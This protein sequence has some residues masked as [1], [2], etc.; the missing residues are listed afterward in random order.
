MKK[1]TKTI[2]NSLSMLLVLLSFIL[3]NGSVQAEDTW[4]TLMNEAT[5]YRSKGDPLGAKNSLMR[6]EAS[7][8]DEK[9]WYGLV[10]I[11]KVYKSMGNTKEESDCKNRSMKILEESNH[12]F[13]LVYVGKTMSS[14]VEF[15]HC[16]GKAEKA[17]EARDHNWGMKYISQCYAS[18]GENT[19][20]AAC[21][22]RAESMTDRKGGDVSFFIDEAYYNY[23]KGNKVKALSSMN[24]AEETA[25]RKNHAYSMELVYKTYN[26]IGETT[27]GSNCKIKYN[28]M[29]NN[30]K[31]NFTDIDFFISEAYR[32]FINNDLNGAKGALKNAISMAGTSNEKIKVAETINDFYYIEG[33]NVLLALL[34]S[35][36][37]RTANT[38]VSST[39]TS[40][41]GTPTMPKS[42]GQEAS[43]AANA[44]WSKD[45]SE[46]RKCFR[47][48]KK[49]KALQLMKSCKDLALQSQS[50]ENLIA[51]GDLYLQNQDRINCTD[52]YRKAEEIATNSRSASMLEN[53]AGKYDSIG[54][55]LAA[56]NCRNKAKSIKS[57]K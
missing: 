41:S 26:A 31:S 10:E 13:G 43:A 15:K 34:K 30:Q 38:T 56:S 39:S 4:R 22:S 8:R 52:C 45:F 35:N 21:L 28:S 2:K 55:K 42:S 6:A 24:K 11:S 27:Q 53:L 40:Q 36:K 46:A 1:A 32:S 47:E 57:G 29:V 19:Q 48:G 23:R 37:G 14:S 18:I 3:L 54:N 33:F 5:L 17:A 16:L 25:T 20:S 50:C 51:T 12:I 44:R 7:A 9:N 49:S